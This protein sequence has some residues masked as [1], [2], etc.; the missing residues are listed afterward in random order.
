M[1]N[2]APNAFHFP[3][4]LTRARALA[5]ARSLSLSCS[6]S[7]SLSLIQTHVG[8]CVVTRGCTG[9]RRPIG[10][11]KLQVILGKRATNY[12]AL[13]RKMTYKD[14]ASYG[15]SAP[16]IKGSL[17][18]SRI[19]TH[20]GACV[21][22]RGCI[23]GSLCLSLARAY[24]CALSLCLFNTQIVT[25]HEKSSVKAL[26]LYRSCSCTRARARCLSPS[27]SLSHTWAVVS[28]DKSASKA[29]AFS[30]SRS[31]S[32]SFFL[33]LFLSHFLSPSLSLFLTLSLSHTHICGYISRL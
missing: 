18:L 24:V 16:C 10:Y 9:W 17:S 2:T 30:L 26:C 22:T 20:I 3:L 7:L 25:S 33:S 23:K 31:V 28:Q 13:L 4:S 14:K 6:I 12:R 19:Q 1:N 32:L 27:L 11:L 8:A 21:K 29:R 5:R 15:S